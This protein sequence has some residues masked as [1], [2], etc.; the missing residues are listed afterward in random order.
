LLRI[1]NKYNSWS[2]VDCSQFLY[3]RKIIISPLG[4]V[5]FKRA[6]TLLF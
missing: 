5:F 6:L 2:E 4:L 1:N 3:I